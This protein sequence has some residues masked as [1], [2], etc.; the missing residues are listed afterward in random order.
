MHLTKKSLDV[1]TGRRQVVEAGWLVA[2]IRY[3]LSR[4]AVDLSCHRKAVKSAKGRIAD[5]IEWVRREIRA[6]EGKYRPKAAIEAGS[7]KQ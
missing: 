1:E 3:S 5:L 2:E 7:R 4:L 6:R